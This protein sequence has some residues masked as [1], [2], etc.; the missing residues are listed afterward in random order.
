MAPWNKKG[1]Y[2]GDFLAD[3]K[4]KFLLM[5]GDGKGAFFLKLNFLH[6]LNVNIDDKFVVEEGPYDTENAADND[7]PSRSRKGH[8]GLAKFR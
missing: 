2:I 8:G 4:E 6:I 5:T 7:G 1:D 3:I